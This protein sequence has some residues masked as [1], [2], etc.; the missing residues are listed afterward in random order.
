MLIPDRWYAVLDSKEIPTGKPLGVRRLG[1]PLVFWR[2]GGGRAVVMKDRCPHRS[3]QLSLGR[4]VNGHIQCP[5]H[6]FEFAGDGACQL[7]PANGRSARIPEIFQCPTYPSQE[8]HGFI[9]VWYGKPRHE[10]PPI[11]WFDGLEGF[12]YAAIQKAWDVDVSRA[13]EGLL[14]VSHLPFVHP[15]TIGRDQKTLVNGPYTTLEEDVLRVWISNQPDEG[16][17]AM[18]P[19]QLPPPEGEATIEFR[20]PNLWRLRIAEQVRAVN[21]IAPVDEG[22]CVIYLRSY[23]KLPLPSAL[24]RL[25]AKLSNVFNRRVLAEDYP[26]IRSQTP[27]VTDLNIG[28]RFIPADRPIAIYLQHRRD[29]IEAARSKTDLGLPTIIGA[30]DQSRE[31]YDADQ[32]AAGERMVQRDFS[33]G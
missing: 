9:W 4:V 14:D 15:R 27:K 26:V 3:S 7:I 25:I 32:D 10:Y 31:V 23:L 8:A 18:K 12:E 2:D 13:I 5:F 29:L 6:G 11:P 28:E 16:L 22:E 30:P 24:T 17:P 21:V 20:F 1:E 19:S 33:K